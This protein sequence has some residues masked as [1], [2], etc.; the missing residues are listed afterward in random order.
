M[1]ILVFGDSIAQGFHD[2]VAGGWCNRLVTE[3]IK[4]GVESGY[5]DERSVV[6]LGISGDTTFDL[7]KRVKTEAESRIL[8]YPTGSYDVALVAIGV[9]DTQY[10][11]ETLVPKFSLKETQTNLEKVIEELQALNMKIVFVGLS[12]VYESR[13]QPMSWKP[14]HG[15]SNQIIAERNTLIQVLATQNNS[16]FIDMSEVFESKEETVLPDGIHPNAKGHQMMFERIKAELEKLT[17][18]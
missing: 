1:R 3:V 18:L 17:I 7:L 12:S 15:Y 5:E 4:R 10:D 14:T 16:T 13:I 9:N 11:M 8:K 6:N 2:E